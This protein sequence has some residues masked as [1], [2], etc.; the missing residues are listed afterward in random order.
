M[1]SFLSSEARAFLKSFP[2][3]D[4]PTD[5]SRIAEIRNELIKAQEPASLRAITRHKLIRDE[6]FIG[7]VSCE[8]IRTQGQVSR[9]TL[10]YFFG[11]GFVVGCPYSD[12]SIIGALAEWCKV[13][14]IAPRYRLAPENPAPAAADDCM[15]VWSEIC[16]NSRGRLYLAGESAGG[17]LALVVAQQAVKKKWRLPDAMALLSPAVDLRPDPALLAP[18]TN[19]DP[20]IQPFRMVEICRAY[21]VDFEL[22]DANLSPLFGSFDDLPPTIITTGTR[23]M[24]LSMCLRLHRQMLRAEVEVEC[25][26]W[27]GLWHVFEYYDDYPEASE[28]LKEIAE[29]LSQHR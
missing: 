26:V 15:S 10:V 5:F 9:G 27:D 29:Y 4:S 16:A 2:R 7:G 25:R 13:E 6:V 8:R 14:V 18:T 28:S 24:L 22:T 17:N 11:G 23:D 1:Y 12:M 3:D 19:A 20:T 21:A